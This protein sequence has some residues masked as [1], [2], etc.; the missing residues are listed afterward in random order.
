VLPRSRVAV[1]QGEGHVAILTAPELV[2]GQ[3]TNFLLD[4]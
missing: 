4:E 1:L 2:A 3:V